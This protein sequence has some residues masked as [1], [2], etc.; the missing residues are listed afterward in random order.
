MSSMHF[1][2]VIKCCIC[3][4]LVSLG[5]CYCSLI[6]QNFTSVLCRK[7]KTH[8]DHLSSPRKCFLQTDK[9]GIRKYSHIIVFLTCSTRRIKLFFAYMHW[10]ISTDRTDTYVFMDLFQLPSMLHKKEKR[11]TWRCST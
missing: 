1:P 7:L 9:C 5:S 4:H 2:P 6:N 11:W 8:V 10:P 3:F